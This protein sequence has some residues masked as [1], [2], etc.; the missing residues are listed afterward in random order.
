MY[1]TGDVEVAD[2]AAPLSAADI[3]ELDALIDKAGS[4]D[5][6]AEQLRAGY[7]ADAQVF[8]RGKSAFRGVS[9]RENGKWYAQIRLGAGSKQHIL[10]TVWVEE[11][12]R[13]FVFVLCDALVSLA[14]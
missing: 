9:Q 7:K 12:V 11:N 6:A 8:S 13:F 4:P 3:I 1:I 2:T 5:A 10:P 14:V